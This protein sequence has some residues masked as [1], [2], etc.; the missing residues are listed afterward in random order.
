MIRDTSAQDVVLAR[1]PWWRAHRRGLIAGVVAL[2]VALMLAPM[3]QRW[4][5]AEASVSS[6]RLRID[7]VRRGTLLRDVQVPGRVVAAVS[8]TLYAP[9]AG[10]I[11]LKAQAGAKVKQGDVLAEIDSPEVQSLLRQ[12][13]ATLQS[14]D[15][16]VKRQRITTR[17]QLLGTRRAL[18][19][20]EVARDAARR[21]MARAEKSWSIRAISEVEYQRAKDD[22]KKAELGFDH[23]SGD[24]ALSRESLAFEQETRELGLERQRLRVAELQRVV[25]GLSIR[26]PVAGLV[27]S[28]AVADRSAVALNQALLTVVDLGALEIEVQVPETMADD[29]GLGMQAEIRIGSDR[30]PGELVSIAPEI[31]QHQVI[32]RVRFAE[33]QPTSVRQ[34]QR[35]DV[36]ILIEEKPDVLLL[37]RGPF[38]DTGG[39]RIAYVVE[40]GIAVRRQVQVGSTSLSAVEILSGLVEGDQVVISSIDEFRGAERVLIAR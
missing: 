26:A 17:Q 20:A 15:I 1:P 14:L 34:N 36:R 6:E 27:G 23:A 39:G 30:H 35:V 3:M 25:D 21:E 28:V 4:F 11:A 10:T 5:I 9:A 22:L 8:P 12:E 38:V 18:N 2:A 33:G 16:E 32:G 19:E 7:T 31:T 24:A 13:E 40:D 29:L 37:S